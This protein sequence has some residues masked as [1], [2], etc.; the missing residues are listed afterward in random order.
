ME[1]RYLEKYNNIIKIKIEGKNIDNYIKRIIKKKINIIK[2]IPISY[3]EVH[4]IIKLSE[5][6][7]IIKYKTTYQISIIDTYGKIKLKNTI[8]RNYILLLSLIIG[9]I[10]II[11]LSKLIFSIDIIH[12]DKEVRTMIRKELE[13]YGIKKYRFKKKY[14]ELEI[15]ED[16]ILKKNK[17]SLEWIEIIENGTKYIVRVEERKISTTKKN[18][19]YQS[20][21][22]KKN[23]IIT[24]INATKGEKVKEVNNYVKKGETII[25]GYITHPD[26]TITMTSAKGDVYGEVWYKVT[27][28]YPFIYQEEKITGRNKTVY[29]LNFINKRISLLD[30]NK[31]KSFKSKNK[32]LLY[33]PIL[34]INLTKEKQYELIIKD[35]VYP[36]DIAITKAK[37]YISKKLKK[38]NPDIKQIKKIIIISYKE[39]ESK[40]NLKLF[41]TAI[42]KISEEMK[43]TEPTKSSTQITTTNE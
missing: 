33:N 18:N 42:E 35:E 24:L 11:T 41:I 31:Y 20:I 13:N 22:S 23:A 10:L 6:E 15:I 29:V 34:N 26:N 3:K 12:E 37:D 7:K 2:L 9:L 14:K 25:S 32:T 16:K 28:D 1:N 4:L 43:I 27:L 19:N 5:Y 36:I 39:S 17:D 30:F 21:I 40:L 8:K 38:D